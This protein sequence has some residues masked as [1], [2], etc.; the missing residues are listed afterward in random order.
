MKVKKIIKTKKNLI[1]I[2]VYDSLILYRI[3]HYGGNSK[4]KRFILS[5]LL[6]AFTSIF[7]FGCSDS[8]DD[9]SSAVPVATPINLSNPDS[10]VGTYE[11]SLFY[12]E[13]GTSVV[14]D[15]LTNNCSSSISN[16]FTTSDKCKDKDNV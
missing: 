11:I 12:T 10:L 15:I 3:I 14:Y 8:G 16:G 2:Y 4:M 9:S 13:A 5:A 1:Y 7:V 6:L